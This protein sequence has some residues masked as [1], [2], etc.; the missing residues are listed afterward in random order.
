MCSNAAVELYV[1]TLSGYAVLYVRSIWCGNCSSC[2]SCWNRKCAATME[3][4]KNSL[5]DAPIWKSF[6]FNAELVLSS[7]KVRPKRRCVRWLIY[8]VSYAMRTPGVMQLSYHNRISTN[9]KVRIPR[10]M[11][12]NVIRYRTIY[13]VTKLRLNLDSEESKSLYNSLQ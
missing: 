7:T 1:F 8:V 3:I 11:K 12:W 6:T 10:R 13:D 2:S 4:G 5:N 9:C